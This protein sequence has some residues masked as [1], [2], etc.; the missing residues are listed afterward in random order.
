MEDRGEVLNLPATLAELGLA[1]SV[2]ADAAGLA[3]VVGG[4]EV[5]DR[6]EARGLDVDRLRRR[7]RHRLDVG[8]RVDRR[9]PGHPL[10]NGLQNR[11]RLLGHVGVLEPGSGEGLD[12]LPVEHRIGFDVDR[13]A[14]VEALEV[15]RVDRAGLDQRRDQLVVP[16]VGRVEL[17]PQRRVYRQPRPQRLDRGARALFPAG[18]PHRVDEVNRP[19]LAPERRRQVGAG[20]AQRQIQCCRLKRPAAVVAGDVFA[21]WRPGREEVDFVQAIGELGEGELAGEALRRPVALLTDVVHRVVD[22]ILADPLL[23]ATT[24]LDDRRQPFERAH[25]NFEPLELTTIYLKR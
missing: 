10:R 15:H 20:L 2:G 25:R 7:P 16:V 22:H 19:R 8:D 24:Q 12:H 21:L 5:A 17:E 9:V 1:A 11:P 6:T 18:Q 23:T 14:F 13:R 3:V 4:E